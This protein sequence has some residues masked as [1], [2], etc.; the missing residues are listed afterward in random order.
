M[1]FTLTFVR[2]FLISW[3]IWNIIDRVVTQCQWSQC[4]C[5]HA[6]VQGIINKAHLD[7][8]RTWA[9]ICLCP[10][11]SDK[12]RSKLYKTWAG[13]LLNVSYSWDSTWTECRG[14]AKACEPNPQQFLRAIQKRILLSKVWCNRTS[15]LSN[16]GSKGSEGTHP[17]LMYVDARPRPYLVEA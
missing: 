8:A 7:P 5:D 14:P 1:E 15:P 13:R 9:R 10:R 2:K 12:R 16:S 11:F 6:Q 4:K 17:V 3:R